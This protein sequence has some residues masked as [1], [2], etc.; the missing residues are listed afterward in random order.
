MTE[1]GVLGAS[2]SVLTLAVIGWATGGYGG[3]AIGT[4]IGL[5]L[6][7]VPWRGQPAW[8]WAMLRAKRYRHAERA[9]P[10]TVANDRSGGGVRYQDGVVIT[11]I[12]VLGRAH[13]A[14]LLIGSTMSQTDNTL[15]IPGLLT[16]LKHNLGMPFQSVSVVSAGSRRRCNG[17]FPRVYDTF[18]GTSPYAGQRETWLVLRINA[19]DSAESLQWRATAGTAALAATQRV[20][21]A[22]SCAGIRARVATATEIVDLDRQLG[23]SAL[24]TPGSRWHSLRG[25]DGWLT[26]YGYDAA[27]LSTDALMMP[28]SL[29]VDGVVQNV[30]LFPDATVTATV[31]IRTPQPPTVAP[32][33]ALQTFA[34]QQDPLL[35]GQLC[36]PLPRVRG[37]SRAQLPSALAV[38]I[39]SCGVLLG[40][41]SIGDRLLLPLDDPFGHSHVHLAVDDSIAKRILIRAAAAGGQVTVHTTDP[42]RWSSVRMPNVVVTDLTRPAT[43]TTISVIDGTVAPSPRPATVLSVAPGP[44]DVVITQTGPA[45]VE[46]SAAG[47]VHDVE[48]EFFRA[49]NRYAPAEPVP[50]R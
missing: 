11:A 18:I 34:G 50:A 35:R 44:A 7:A 2:A 13:R 40:K 22:M 36:E 16:I 12:Q 46:I 47:R 41:V 30:T 20:A 49:E 26:S 48:M 33:T 27:R 23:S 17:D 3:A 32:N 43:G 6:F 37:L 25:E 4:V 10:T 28:W 1:L 15:E 38:P 5:A 14:T 39:G 8:V 45:T 19:C 24:E 29:R 21:A 42:N 9:V 31:T